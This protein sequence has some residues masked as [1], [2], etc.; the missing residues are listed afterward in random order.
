MEDVYSVAYQKNEGNELDFAYFGMFDG[1]AGIFFCVLFTLLISINFLF[2]STK[3]LKRVS[4][5]KEFA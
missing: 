1:Y 4:S 5:L 3:F 2:F